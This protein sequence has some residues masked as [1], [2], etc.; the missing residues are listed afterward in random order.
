VIEGII[1]DKCSRVKEIDKVRLEE[2]GGKG[3]KQEV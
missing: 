2:R 1:Q 3:V